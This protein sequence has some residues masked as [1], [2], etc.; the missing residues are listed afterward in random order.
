MARRG[1][2]RDQAVVIRSYDF[3]EADR[4]VVLLTQHHGVVR[5]VARGVR[6]AK[7]RFGSRV[8]PFVELDVLLYPGKNLATL[9]GADT[10]RYFGSGII[11]DYQRY[12]AA[13]AMLEI[14][15]SLAHADPDPE[16]YSSVT[17]ALTSIQHSPE[18]VLDLDIFIL[19]VMKI[20]GWS[21][22]L[23]YCAQCNAPGP[24]R[25]FHPL[26]GGAVCQY[27]RPPGSFN[28]DPEVLHLMWLLQEGHRDV[29][30][31]TVREHPEYLLSIHKLSAVHLR[32]HLETRLPS[33][34]IFDEA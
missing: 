11:E 14:A 26:S 17:R 31:E 5:S 28:I 27:C 20:S 21:P 13:C 7:S 18:P 10:V 4:V 24:H 23:F 9:S 33:L 1:S 32:W 3:A 6:R 29:V 25:S 16:L 15:E 8:Q 12:T 2:Y 19:H 22:S 30:L 34:A